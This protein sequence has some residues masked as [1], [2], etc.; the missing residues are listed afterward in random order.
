MP[1]YTHYTYHHLHSS[2]RFC[3]N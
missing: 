2:R 1:I 3:I